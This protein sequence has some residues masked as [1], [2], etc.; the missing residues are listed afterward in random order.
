MCAE[1]GGLTQDGESEKG[2][3]KRMTAGRKLAWPRCTGCLA[4]PTVIEKK[5]NKKRRREQEEKV[6]EGAR[7][8]RTK[9]KKTVEAERERMQE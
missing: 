6:E 8:N 5:K 4:T 1:G 3:R 7:G 9:R 2:G